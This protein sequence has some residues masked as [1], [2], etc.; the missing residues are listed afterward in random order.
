M[1]MKKEKIV[2]TLL[3]STLLLG[4]CA[5]PF[6][7]NGQSASEST[8]AVKENALNKTILTKNIDDIAQYDFDNNKVFG[9]AY[10]VY[11]NGE[12][13]EKCYG[14]M[15]LNSDM[16]ITNTTLFRLASMTKPITAVA[17]LVAMEKGLLSLDDTVDKFIPEFK[18]IQIKDASGKVSGLKKQPT[19]LNILTHTSGIG[20]DAQKLSAMTS[21]DQAT[22]NSAIAF[23]LGSGLDFE[24]G[25]KQ[26]YSAT[27]AF[28]VLVKI[29]E[30]ATGEDYLQF[31]QKNIFEPCNM[32]DTTFLPTDE[33]W[34]RI[35][36]MH[37]QVNGENAVATMPEGCIFGNVP[38]THYLGGAG[39]V[40][41]LQDYANFAK[42]LLNGGQGEKGKVI[43]TTSVK[44]LS[45][46][47]I[48]KDV[49]PGNVRWGLGVR[50]ITKKSY[51][52]L[53]VGS[54]GWSGAYGSHFW[55]DPVNNV[56]AVYMKN[57]HVDGGAS[58]ESANKFEKAVYTALLLN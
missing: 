26:A 13:T 33:Q 11:D 20:S 19:I 18:Q 50:V 49:M 32:K 43:S 6:G 51:P 4:G 29:I 42:M 2:A 38:V 41:T 27:G 12:I 25:T 57:S 10:Y 16:P 52:H 44:L 55:I 58:N 3:A 39:L 9:S 34:G 21:A 1:T 30:T 22:L 36:D 40:S 48:S 37:Q 17:A 54:F 15:S 35:V 31:L 47:Q 56:F 8:S 45:S 14:N 23:Y 5:L 53:P 46:A 7:P 28:D 24:P